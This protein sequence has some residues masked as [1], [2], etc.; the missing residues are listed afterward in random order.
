MKKV[1]SALDTGGEPAG[2]VAILES[3]RDVKDSTPGSNNSVALLEFV[4]SEM[5]ILVFRLPL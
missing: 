3:P 2:S 4:L 5:F 1:N